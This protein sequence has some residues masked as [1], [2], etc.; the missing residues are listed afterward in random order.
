MFLF[1]SAYFLSKQ[2]I[3]Y[4]S[5]NLSHLLAG[6]VVGFTITIRP[7]VAVF[8]VPLLLYKQWKILIGSA[9]GIVAGLLFSII[10]S[11]LSIWQRYSSAM[12]IHGLIKLGVIPS[13]LR[14]DLVYPELIEGMKNLSDMLGVPTVST[15]IMG[16]FRLLGIQLYP[17][18]LTLLLGIILSIMCFFIIKYRR[19][20]VSMEL[21]FLFG[22]YMLLI[23]E[24]FTP[25]MRY[26]YIDIQWLM[27]L[28]LIIIQINESDFLKN[29]LNVLLLLS[30]LLSSGFN[31][32]SFDLY[33]SE[34]LMVLYVTSMTFLILREESK[35]RNRIHA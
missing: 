35:K 14:T 17:Q 13:N 28:S 20:E 30:L 34:A 29:K 26:S 33:I 1:A 5:L 24:F 10:F 25:S 19:P 9:I 15:S 31:W 2:S 6:L 4:K 18:V 3:K 22:S 12:K 8:V 16:I 11:D 27:P 21:L 32:F 23:S 7:P